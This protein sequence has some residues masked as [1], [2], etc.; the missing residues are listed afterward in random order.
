MST[1]PS[2]C[3]YSRICDRIIPFCLRKAVVGKC[4]GTSSVSEGFFFSLSTD[5]LSTGVV[6]M[7]Q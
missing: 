1:N 4:H 5:S 3:L 7:S 2:K 6:S